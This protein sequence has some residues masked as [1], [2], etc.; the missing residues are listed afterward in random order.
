[1]AKETPLLP[2]EDA[3]EM[4]LFFVVGALCFLAALATL[5]AKSTYG[6]ARSW[7][8]EVEG[9]LTVSLPD[10]DRRGAESARKLIESTEGVKEARL[11]SKAEIDALLEPNF[12]SRGLPESL[13]LPQLIA[14]T[15]EPDAQFVGPT[16]ERRLTEAGFANAVDEHADWAGDVRRMLSI[17]RLV[18]LTAVALLASTAIAVIAFATH[19]ALLARRDIV[20]VLHLAGARDRYIAGLFERRFWLLGLRAGAVGAL[21]AL[22][23][24]AAMIFAVHSSGAR[25]GL[26]PELSLDFQDLLI[27]VLTPVI[28][29]LAARIAARMTVIRSLKSVM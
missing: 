12:G 14:V 6:A 21:L 19:A 8:A 11:L 15:A 2:V 3:R 26:L 5:S 27:L 29:G 20:D 28:A 1:M 22:G 9:E 17:A 23:A 16:L 18:A 24:A 10:A 4:A 13:P 7:T 25:T